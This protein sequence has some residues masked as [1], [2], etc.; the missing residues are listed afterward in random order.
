MTPLRKVSSITSALLSDKFPEA[1][2]SFDAVIHAKAKPDARRLRLSL[3]RVLMAIVTIRPQW[4]NYLL[5]QLRLLG[6]SKSPHLNEEPAL[7]PRPSSA[8]L[9]REMSL[10]ARLRCLRVVFRLS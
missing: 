7:C 1:S 10:H 6:R 3:Q 9:L 8:R 5:I 2:M 4:L